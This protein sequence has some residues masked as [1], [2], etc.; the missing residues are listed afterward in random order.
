MCGAVRRRYGIEAE[1][2]LLKHMS[3]FGTKLI[4]KDE[5]LRSDTFAP[6]GIVGSFLW[7]VR[8]G[9]AF[10]EVELDGHGRERLGP[11]RT[12]RN[13]QLYP[14]EFHLPRERNGELF[15][16]D[17]VPP[18]RGGTEQPPVGGTTGEADKPQKRGRGRPKKR[19]AAVD[20]VVSNSVI[21]GLQPKLIEQALIE[22]QQTKDAESRQVLD[23]AVE[24]SKLRF[25]VEA[26]VTV[27]GI[28]TEVI[29]EAKKKPTYCAS[30][31]RHVLQGDRR[32]DVIESH[33]KK[34]DFV[35]RRVVRVGK[36]FS[37]SVCGCDG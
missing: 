15:G 36:E 24:T 33:S 6:H 3:Q 7:P 31:V 25:S 17:A 32:V 4:A 21:A 22:E 34:E 13:Y 16:E 19:I 5:S 26:S 12:T 20:H 35:G 11:V 1:K 9:V 8:A 37:R 10:A 23:D 28:V 29:D 14:G 2:S 27:D 30:K 18:A